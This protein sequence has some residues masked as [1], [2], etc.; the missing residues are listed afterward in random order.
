MATADPR[1]LIPV[2]ESL[3][4]SMRRWLGAAES[5]Q[6]SV[7]GAVAH[8]AEQADQALGRCAARAADA[9][10]MGREARSVLARALDLKAEADHAAGRAD[11]VTARARPIS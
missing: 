11:T 7:N 5:A 9:E 1:I 6:Q 3:A 2:V 4:T 8:A 10:R